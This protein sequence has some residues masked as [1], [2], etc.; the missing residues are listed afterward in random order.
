M[1]A[2]HVRETLVPLLNEYYDPMYRY[3][4]EK[5]ADKIVF[6]GTSEAV[7]HWLATHA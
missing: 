4:L 1:S 3:Q 5:K 7:V 6:R 2:V